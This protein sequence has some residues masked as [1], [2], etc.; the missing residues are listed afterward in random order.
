MNTLDENTRAVGSS[1]YFGERG[2]WFIAIAI[3][4]DG[5]ALSRSNFACMEKALRALD[6]VKNW[7]GDDAPIQTERFTHWAVGWCD[8]LLVNSE[9][10]EA[11]ALADKLLDKLD[12]YPILNEEHFSEEEMNEANEVWSNCYDAKERVAYI[13]ARR[14][15]FEFHD[16]ADM[17][18]CLRGKYFSGYASEL[19]S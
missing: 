17:L 15:Q 2:N 1:A 16:F 10:K 3:T 6:A 19:L 4:R 7:T 13:R 5:D 11:V 8:Y 14:R 12:D 9:C 18:G